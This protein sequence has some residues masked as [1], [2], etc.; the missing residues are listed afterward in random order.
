[1]DGWIDGHK[2]TKR[3]LEDKEK[4]ARRATRNNQC[5]FKLRAPGNTEEQRTEK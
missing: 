3:R 4:S 5:M 1:M 2:I